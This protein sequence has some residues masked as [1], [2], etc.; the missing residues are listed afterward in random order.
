[1]LKNIFCLLLPLLFVVS[2]GSAPQTSETEVPWKNLT[3]GN[4]LAG[5]TSLGG[6]ATYK[7]EDGVVT[8]TTV[9]N[10]P[11]TFLTTDEMYGDF[12]LELDFQVDPSMNSG[13]QFRSNSLPT[14][15]NG[16]VHGYQMEI[17]P[18]KRAW[19]GGI[20]DEGRR[21]WL[22]NLKDNPAGQAAFKQNEWNT[23]RLEA[24][25]DSIRIWLNGVPTAHLV[26][27]MTA[28]GFIG[29]QVHSIHGDKEPGTEIKW[30]NVKILTE[31]LA[32]YQRV[33]DLPAVTTL[34]Q[35]TQD[36]EKNEFS[37]LFDGQSTDQWRGAKLTD[38]PAGGWSVSDKGVLSIAASGGAESAAAG[39][40]VT[41]KKYGNFELLVDFRL[42]EGANS[43]IK[44]YVD[45]EMNQGAGSSIGLEYQILDDAVH[46]DAKLGNHEGSRTLASV[47]DLIQ[48][49][50]N[51]PANPIGEWNQ[52]RIVSNEGK[53]QHFL[54]G[55]EVLSYDRF[56][57]EFEQLVKESK[58]VDWDGFGQLKE[59]HILLQDHGDLVDYRNLKIRAL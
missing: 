45:T 46:P 33:I 50:P 49:D 22:V 14:Y 42:S 4:D 27:D 26:D 17:D 44:Y 35:L 54:N 39:D 5:W 9:S 59:G 43:G 6:D 48:A 16:R 7:M 3:V 52:A 57:P 38:F 58:Y 19:S 29:L 37:L 36:E 11:N 15:Q 10:T 47:Y 30:R 1:M 8:G 25:G 53:V 21:K 55:T 2:C 34:N 40:I 31:N 28:E 51:K 12:I 23:Y 18:S 56:S 32:R 13:V 24:I 41:K 20:F